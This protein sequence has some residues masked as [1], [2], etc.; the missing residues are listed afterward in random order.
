MSSMCLCNM[1]DWKLALEWYE[2][3]SSA[4]TPSIILSLDYA[5]SMVTKSTGA[6]KE[7]THPGIFFFF[8]F[9]DILCAHLRPHC[10]IDML[11]KSLRIYKV[12][13][14]WWWYLSPQCIFF[15][16]IESGRNSS[17][18]TRNKI[19]RTK[20]DNNTIHTHAEASSRAVLLIP[21]WKT[22][23][24]SLPVVTK[25]LTFFCLCTFFFFLSS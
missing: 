18:N 13:L 22:N 14:T 10:L 4:A 5:V 12:T 2:F 1:T 9:L 3:L 17:L 25:T 8:F 6:H 19:L 20:S 15:F 11:E 23:R 7:N 16:F 24:P 21:Q